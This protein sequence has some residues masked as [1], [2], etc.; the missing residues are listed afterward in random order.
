MKEV[1]IDCNGFRLR[2]LK[3]FACTREH[4]LSEKGMMFSSVLLHTV[5][6]KTARLHAW[7][8]RFQIFVFRL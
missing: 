3:T 7:T 8:N 6:V 1:S 2:H 5:S 4:A